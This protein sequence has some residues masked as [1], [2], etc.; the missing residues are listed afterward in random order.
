MGSF[1]NRVAQWLRTHNI[2][3]YK[4]NFNG[5]DWYYSERKSYIN[6][7]DYKGGLDT[8]SVWLEQLIIRHQIDSIV[9]FG[10]C[11]KYHQLA[12]KITTQLGRGF[13]VFEEGY[14][15]PN[16]I[17][18]E[19]VGVNAFS[20]FDLKL[21]EKCKELYGESERDIL[22]VDNQY[23]LMVLSAIMYY[24]FT[25]L[26]T[27]TYRYYHH[28]RGLSAW[29]ELRAWLCSGLRR[30]YNAVFEPARIRKF[31]TSHRDQ[32]FVFPLQV[33]NDSQILV[34]SDLK[35]MEKYIELVVSNFSQYADPQHQLLL[36][37]H[38]MDRGYRH[39]AQYIKQLGVRYDCA[40]RL[41]YFCD[42]HLPTVLKNSLGVVTVNSTTGLQAL[43]HA[44]PVKV[45]GAAIYNIEGLTAQQDLSL[46]WKNRT[47]VDFENYE[48]FKKS[49][50]ANS[51]LN[52]AYYGKSHWMN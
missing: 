38:P 15:R 24:I 39:Y 10:D 23:Y 3:S 28:H 1:F 21:D 27:P 42:V 43:Y 32:Y 49:L 34:H 12:K 14:I 50:I 5:G 26:R 4:V 8:F 2:G 51:Q 29:S 35:S 44:A 30:L 16:F 36:K 47:A 9:C 33:H 37:H 46:F 45:L 41:H 31:I 7:F 22:A 25:V 6:C 17:T 11:R 40:E 13:Y 48:Y 52:G 20:T 18:F 19:Q